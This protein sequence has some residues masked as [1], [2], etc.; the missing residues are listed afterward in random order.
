MHAKVKELLRT[1]SELAQADAKAVESYR[2]GQIDEAALQQA[3][4]ANG[5]QVAACRR[6][7]AA[8]PAEAA[9]A[10]GEV[11]QMMGRIQAEL[12]QVEADA[13][14]GRL[15]AARAQSQTYVLR[16]KFGQMM[17]LVSELEALAPIDDGLLAPVAPLS[18]EEG[19]PAPVPAPAPGVSRRV[20]PPQASRPRGGMRK[21]LSCVAGPTGLLLLLLFFLPW[22]NVTCAGE[23]VASMSGLQMST[24]GVSMEEKVADRA[25]ERK[26]DVSAKPWNFLGLLLPMG[27]MAAGALGILGRLSLRGLAWALLIA[28]SWGCW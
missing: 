1:L 25:S 14:Q 9:G 11:R 24:G 26:E 12:A 4:Q 21:L 27:V 15:D 10:L 23:H 17:H 2:K 19:A 8:L 22:V 28:A 16:A 18:V 7:L 20:A 3:R 6:G 5:Q 13:S